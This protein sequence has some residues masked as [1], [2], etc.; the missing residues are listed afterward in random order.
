[1]KELIF[2]LA[3]R[4]EKTHIMSHSFAPNENECAQIFSTL[5]L[6]DYYCSPRVMFVRVCA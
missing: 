6:P 1:M 4:A 2:L 3:P 5:A